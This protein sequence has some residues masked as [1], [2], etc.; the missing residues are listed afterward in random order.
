MGSTLAGKKQVRIYILSTMSG[1]IWGG[2]EELWF[3]MASFALAENHKLIIEVSSWPK[4]S[5]SIKSLLKKRAKIIFRYVL[6]SKKRYGWCLAAYSRCRRFLARYPSFNEFSPDILCISEGMSYSALMAP[7]IFRRVREFNG[8]YI[9]II[10]S[11]DE[12]QMPDPETLEKARPFYEG[13]KTIFTVTNRHQILLQQQLGLPLNK[14]ALIKNPIKRGSR[15]I[16]FP[17][18]EPAQLAVVAR[19]CIADKGQDILLR[20]LGKAKWSNRDWRLNLY[21]D[22]PDKKK[23]KEMVAKFNLEGRVTFCGY[24]PELSKIW[25]KNQI[26]IF[27]SRR[28][29]LPIALVEALT[30]G[31]CAIV[32]DIGGNTELVKDGSSGFVALKV[33]EESID[34]T[35]ERAWERKDQWEQ[36][37]LNARE[38]TLNWIDYNPGKTLLDIITNIHDQTSGKQK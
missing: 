18:M 38:K 30:S 21:G 25:S 26:A 19:L 23:L 1:A 12:T 7:D 31:R 33:T 34:A 35:I 13:A 16:Q 3:E 22:G 4:I 17:K 20:V 15:Y 37:G 2:S 10:Q 8:P 11:H 36:L 32:T 29:G 5:D 14:F 28:E 27:P 9:V 6:W 24:E